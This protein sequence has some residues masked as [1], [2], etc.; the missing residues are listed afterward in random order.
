MRLCP[1]RIGEQVDFTTTD[2][3]NVIWPQTTWTAVEG[4]FPLA[5]SSG[6]ALGSTGGSESKSYT[7]TGTVGSHTLTTSEIPAHTHGSRSLT[8]DVSTY[9]DTGLI[10][11]NS[12]RSGVFGLGSK[13]SDSYRPSWTSGSSYKL[14]IDCSHTHDSVGGSGGH[15]HGFTGTASTLDVMPP[16]TTVNRWK[17]VA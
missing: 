6:H 4:S 2:N 8:G 3:P 17:R 13:V 14:Y 7:P 11:G 1:H 12:L 5:S 10:G 9:S 16:Y 15:D